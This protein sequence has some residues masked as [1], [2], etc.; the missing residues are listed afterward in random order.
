V[1]GIANGH[2]LHEGSQSPQAVPDQEEESTCE[3]D[4]LA[5]KPPA[6]GLLVIR[7]LGFGIVVILVFLRRV[8]SVGEPISPIAATRRPSLSR[9]PPFAT[10]VFC[11]LMAAGTP[12]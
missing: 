4:R 9:E 10:L 11:R 12:V 1:P 5:T 7:R 6:P 3:L 2:A 8:R